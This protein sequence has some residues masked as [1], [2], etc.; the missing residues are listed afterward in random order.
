MILPVKVTAKQKCSNKKPLAEI[1]VALDCQSISTIVAMAT[2][3]TLI[4]S[5]ELKKICRMRCLVTV[6][7]YEINW[8]RKRH[9]MIFVLIRLIV[10][11]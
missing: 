9:R 1:T 11:V 2:K 10:P 7:R 8:H 4:K 5:D 3:A 6:L